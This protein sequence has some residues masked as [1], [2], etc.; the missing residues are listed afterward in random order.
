M[1]ELDAVHTYYGASHILQGVSLTVAE[2]EVLGVLG[3]NGMGKTT[4]VHTVAGL[5]RPRRG[6][7]RFLGRDI[8][9]ASAERI[10]RAGMGL[11]PQGHRVFPSLSVKENLKVAVRRARSGGRARGTVADGVPRFPVLGERWGLPAGVLSGGQQQ[12]LALGRA[13]V[14]NARLVL[15]DEPTEGLD[16]QTV[17]RVGDVV[18]ELRRRGTS[19]VLVEQKVDFALRR[20]DRVVV[21]GRGSVVHESADPAGLRADTATLRD[22]LAVGG[23]VA[24]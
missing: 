6:R 22:L 1:L 11:V 4:L 3:R 7:I 5:L 12:M 16:P 9:G 20:V 19:A 18:D 15:L 24:A 14:G 21:I 13:L 23:T 2:G 17:A 10:S 8:T